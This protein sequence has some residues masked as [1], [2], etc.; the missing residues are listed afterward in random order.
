MA[1]TPYNPWRTGGM[2]WLNVA[3]IELVRDLLGP[4]LRIVVVVQGCR[5]RCPGC[6]AE[7][8]LTFQTA[9]LCRP[10][11]LAELFIQ[12]P[13]LEGLTFSGGE[14]MLQAAGLACLARAVRK[15]RNVNVICF[16]GYQLERLHKQPPGA[17]VGELLA[18]TDVLI[19]GPYR[20]ELDDNQGL[21]GSS[22]QRIHILTPALQPWADALARQPRKAE[23]RIENG[24]V[25]LIGV[26]PNHMV[27]AVEAALSHYHK[28]IKNERG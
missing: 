7:G 14:P 27:E 6:I 11:T 20:K 25:T 19:D 21:R 4:G 1:K 2:P 9:Q 28:E 13:G 24:V 22:N 26:P 8:W 5:R 16:T 12:A 17:G 15:Q 10:E 23:V 18:E 3:Q